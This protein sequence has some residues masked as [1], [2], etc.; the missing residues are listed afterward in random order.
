MYGVNKLVCCDVKRAGD[1]QLGDDPILESRGNRILAQM[2][3]RL[4]HDTTQH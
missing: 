3:N 1:A 4:G 2:H